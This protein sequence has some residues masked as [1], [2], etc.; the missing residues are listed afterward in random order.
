MKFSTLPTDKSYKFL[1]FLGLLLTALGYTQYEKSNGMQNRIKENT[2]LI[3]SLANDL[4]FRLQDSV[5]SLIGETYGGRAEDRYIEHISLDC[6]SLIDSISLY[7]ADTFF[8]LPPELRHTL[9]GV[10]LTSDQLVALERSTGYTR[11]AKEQQFRIDM[12]RVTRNMD[13]E[14]YAQALMIRR[15]E[16]NIDS[17]Q[18]IRLSGMTL[19][20]AGSWLFVWGIKSWISADRHD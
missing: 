12:Y 8:D 17:L 20:C 4:R 1:T 5:Q 16:K 7:A 15:M 10:G 18:W 6:K 14:L 11:S 13:K 3:D 2:I 9:L 19:F